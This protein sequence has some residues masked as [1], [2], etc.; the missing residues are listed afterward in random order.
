MQP[1]GDVRM[2]SF[3]GLILFEDASRFYACW[4]EASISSQHVCAP[5]ECLSG[6]NSLTACHHNC[7][8]NTEGMAPEKVWQLTMTLL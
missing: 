5:M 3:F 1:R 8:P 7:R 4:L 2:L 6:I